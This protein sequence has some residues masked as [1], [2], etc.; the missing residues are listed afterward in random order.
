MVDCCK[1]TGGQDCDPD[2]DRAV[3]DARRGKDQG[4]DESQADQHEG[5]FY[6]YRSHAGIRR[7]MT[8]LSSMTSPYRRIIC[9]GCLKS[10][11]GLARRRAGSQLGFHYF[12][13]GFDKQRRS[14]RAT[15]QRIFTWETL[16]KAMKAYQDDPEYWHKLY[17]DDPQFRK[18]SHT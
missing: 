15:Y 12:G 5:N 18:Q 4:A 13:S 16:K 3:L 7:A 8:L 9:G 14:L 17:G 11:L 6:K 10:I 2:T 1:D